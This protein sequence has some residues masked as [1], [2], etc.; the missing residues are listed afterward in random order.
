MHGG[1]DDRQGAARGAWADFPALF[2]ENRQPWE[3]NYLIVPRVSSERRYY[4]PTGFMTSDTIASDAVQIIPDAA[5]YHLGV[6]T[7]S[8]HLVWMRAS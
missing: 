4:V 1:T 3:G 8:V 7:S 5:L 6:L 2:M